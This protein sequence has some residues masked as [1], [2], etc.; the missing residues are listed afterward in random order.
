MK[1][2]FSL[3]SL[4]VP[5]FIL[6]LLT[7]GSC[8]KEKST[9]T[10][11][12][13]Q[14]VSF[15]SVEAEAQG[16]TAFND[17]FDNAMG[18]NND[19]GIGGTGI[20]GRPEPGNSFY[21]LD[22]LPP[23][24]TVTITHSNTSNFFP[25]KIAIDFGTAGCSRPSDGHTRKG[26]IIIDYS[27]RLT[28]PGA[29]STTTFENYYIDNIKI[30]GTATIMNSSSQNSTPPTKQYKIDITEGKISTPDGNYVEWNSHK[31]ITQTE[32]LVTPTIP[33]DDVF[34]IEGYA[35]G[36]AQRGNLLVA[37]Q[38]TITT[39]LVKTFACRWITQG[40]VKID[41]ASANTNNTWTG[42]LDYGNGNCDDIA[43]ATVNGVK[44][45]ISLH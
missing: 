40:T 24:A 27:N 19:V 11:Q 28:I 13:Q 8:S 45:Q 34:Q 25:V 14:D 6:S 32:G 22:S 35:N 37:W 41:R 39:P 15:T 5:A 12:Q 21:R 31:T 4:I 16:E 44:R 36:R 33:K 42:Y 26:R 43:T 10:D 20:F 18:A 7:I 30:E 2:S 3:L 23:C 17:V 29:I 1:L 9:A 38:S